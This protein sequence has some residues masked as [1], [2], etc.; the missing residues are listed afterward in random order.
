MKRVKEILRD[1]GL[2]LLLGIGIGTAA[3]VVFGIIG[4]AVGKAGM[5]GGLLAARSGT[6]LIGGFLLVYAAILQ[7]KGGNLPPDAFRLRPWKNREHGIDASLSE[8]ARQ[9]DEDADTDDSFRLFRTVSRRYTS[10]F[11]AVGVLAVAVL[12]DFIMIS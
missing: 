8:M 4:W 5:A 11:T 3:G 10:I 1:L 7:M 12:L 6:M 2:A 9:S